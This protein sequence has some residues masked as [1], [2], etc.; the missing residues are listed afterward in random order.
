MILF[1][2]I[3]ERHPCGRSGRDAYLQ[4]RVRKLSPEQREAARVA[5]GLGRTLRQVAADFDV[6]HETV[7]SVLGAETA[8]QI[9]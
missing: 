1:A 4:P 5:V 6:S 2:Q 7:R 3:P 9:Q 8:A